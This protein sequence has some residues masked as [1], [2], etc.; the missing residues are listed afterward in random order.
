MAMQ[1]FETI[2]RFAVTSIAVWRLS[3]L[4]FGDPG[5]QTRNAATES[6]VSGRFWAGRAGDLLCWISVL[7]S[8]QTAIWVAFGFAGVFASWI[9]LSG[10][11]RL[12]TP[13]AKDVGAL[14]CGELS[15]VAAGDGMQVHHG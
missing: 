15:C 6:S 4:L 8:S 5:S 9:T 10:V 12:F 1:E 11:S 2:W 13:A 14:C 7:M 3:R